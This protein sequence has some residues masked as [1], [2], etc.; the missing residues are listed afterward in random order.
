MKKQ[1]KRDVKRE[2]GNTA[3][4]KRSSPLAHKKEDHKK[5]LPKV[6]VSND[7]VLRTKER[8][9]GKEIAKMATGLERIGEITETRKKS[10]KWDHGKEDLGNKRN[11]WLSKKT[12][13]REKWHNETHS[14]KRSS[15]GGDVN[16]EGSTNSGR[17]AKDSK[18]DSLKTTKTGKRTPV[19]ET[20]R[21][22]CPQGDKTTKIEQQAE[23]KLKEG[24]TTDS[25][26]EEKMTSGLIPRRS[27]V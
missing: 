15:N 14:K 23:K 7:S 22:T 11:L 17:V 16:K 19:E 10:M 1:V 2:H 5:E 26:K 4:T 21:Q 24:K 25:S 18:D 27:R 6:K 13:H 20:R 9:V 8:Q 3:L 12:K